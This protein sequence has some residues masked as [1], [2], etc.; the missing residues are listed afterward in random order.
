MKWVETLIV[1]CCGGDSG[2]VCV[3]VC[4]SIKCE[5]RWQALHSGTARTTVRNLHRTDREDDQHLGSMT[6]RYVTSS[7]KFSLRL[8]FLLPAGI[9]LRRTLLSIILFSLQV[10]WCD[11]WS[12]GAGKM[13]TLHW[14]SSIPHTAVVDFC[15]LF[16]SLVLLLC[17]C[18]IKAL[19]T[20]VSGGRNPEG[21]LQLSRRLSCRTLNPVLLGIVKYWVCRFI[22]HALHR[23][24]VP[25]LLH[26]HMLPPSIINI[27]HLCVRSYFEMTTQGAKSSNKDHIPH[28]FIDMWCIREL[29]NSSKQH[30]FRCF[31][32][33]WTIRTDKAVFTVI[34]QVFTV[35]VIRPNM[36]TYLVPINW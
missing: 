34:Q 17:L 31:H 15:H 25:A 11:Q 8:L 18:G 4:D 3:C 7:W 36:E 27:V 2:C 22:K 5:E 14:V 30:H 1:S 32:G 20:W 12:S 13:F 29:N 6:Q 19:F 24:E 33:C 10:Q 16:Y 28:I 23:P 35:L 9:T 26:V 21:Y